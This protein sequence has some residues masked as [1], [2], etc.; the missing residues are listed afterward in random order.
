MKKQH[1]MFPGIHELQMTI[2]FS[3]ANLN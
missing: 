1:R 2:D 3:F